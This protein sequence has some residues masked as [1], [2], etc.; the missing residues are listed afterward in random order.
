M[1]DILLAIVIWWASAYIYSYTVGLNCASEGSFKLL[2][3]STIACYIEEK[4]K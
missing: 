2:T 4:S 1:S 3:G